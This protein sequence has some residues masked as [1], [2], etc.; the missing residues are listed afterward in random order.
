MPM[1]Q[2][3]EE[4]RKRELEAEIVEPALAKAREITA[5]AEA[6][7]EEVAATGAGEADA[8]RLKGLAEAEAM[9]AKARSWGDY[10]QAA[11]TDRVLEVLP[12]LAAAVSAPLAQTDKI[13]MIG[14]H[15]SPARGAR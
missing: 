15:G 12:A 5:V 13:V 14:G 1:T 7:R 10:N 9:A 6:H 8:L 2:A 11:I 3:E 4:R